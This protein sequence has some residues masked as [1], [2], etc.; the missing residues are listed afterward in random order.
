MNGIV[1]KILVINIL[2]FLTSSCISIKSIKEQIQE[3]N[4]EVQI[5]EIYEFWWTN[6]LGLHISFHDGRQLYLSN[7]RS[8]LKAPFRVAKVG[9]YIFCSYFQLSDGS[10]NW[11]NNTVPIGLIGQ[12][13]GLSL[14]T[15]HDVIKH[16]DT[17]YSY[18]LSL[19]D[20]NEE[21]IQAE[22]ARHGKNYEPWWIWYTDM[23]FNKI[24]YRTLENKDGVPNIIN[25]YNTFEYYIFKKFDPG[26]PH[27]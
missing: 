4:P 19:R 3:K 25:Q 23:E 9:E 13:L 8:D 21:I 5:V 26:Y 6:Y 15:V 10:Y 1:S 27:F 2:L 17:I 12:E 11:N 22:I 16:Y 14:N 20:I 7:V 24:V 18:M